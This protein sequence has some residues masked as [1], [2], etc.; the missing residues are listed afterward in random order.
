MKR[1]IFPLVIL[2]LL[3]SQSNEATLTLYKDG[4]G[5]VKQTVQFKV[6]S[7]R[8]A[9]RYTALPDK[10]DPQSAF[11]S[12]QKAEVIYQKFNH[13]VF[14][15]FSFLKDHLGAKVKVKPVW[16][17]SFKGI[18]LNLDGRWMTVSRW[19]STKIVNL[20]EVI[21]IS[22]AGRKIIP[23]VRPELLW[24]VNADQNGEVSGDLIYIARGFDWDADYRLVV[25]PD[26]KRARLASRAIIKNET[27]LTFSDSRL[28]LVEG[29]LRRLSPGA[30]PRRPLQRA[31]PSEA[32]AFETETLGDYYFY[33]LS[34]PLTVPKNESITVSLYTE[35]E[36]EFSRLY[37]FEN[38]ERSSK[39]EPL[40]V[41]L[42]FKN[43]E[44]N[45]LGIPLPSGSFQ[46]YYSTVN[47]V[48]K[49]AGEDFLPQV[50]IDEEARV[51]AGRAFDVL[52]KR[53]VV[54]YSRMKKSEEVTILLEI[55]NK[56]DDEIEVQLREHIYGDW[57]IRD[58]SHE[59]RKTDAQT[60]Q[61]DLRLPPGSTERVT[62]TYLK[63]WQ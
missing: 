55:K 57:V 5:L 37:R 8:N 43:N 27:D 63:A 32:I 9:I 39:E 15:T 1:F 46:I 18:L 56:R 14:N 49:F 30:P 61:F 28:E 36:I 52:G 59:Y 48:V 33:S 50:T 4:Y 45:G 7:G 54:N 42:S 35:K 34:E 19:W 3:F 13:N 20:D 12:L 41:Q 16:G 21:Q 23:S 51:T 29:E 47:G 6:K 38:S 53:I 26:E 60:V 58:P 24:E 25:L 17:R 11:I 22:I 44:E 62:Y 10:I 2:N 40:T 31:A